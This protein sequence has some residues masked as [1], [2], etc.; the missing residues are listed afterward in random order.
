MGYKGHP[1]A[2]KPG[3]R[4][5]S[6]RAA[7][8]HGGHPSLSARVTRPKWMVPLAFFSRWSWLLFQATL[9]LLTL[10]IVGGL[11]FVKGVEGRELEVRRR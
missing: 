5:S 8:E 6:W 10:S 9:R 11:R 7:A 3:E 1:L 2:C 4:V